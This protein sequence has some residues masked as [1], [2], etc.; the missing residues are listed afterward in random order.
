MKITTK[1][2]KDYGACSDQLAVFNENWPDGCE[3]TVDNLVLAAQ[4]SLFC[5]CNT[6]C[7]AVIPIDILFLETFFDNDCE[8]FH[9]Y[10]RLLDEIEADFK[11]V[12]WDP[13]NEWTTAIQREISVAIMAPVLCELTL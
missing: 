11:S 9:E 12:A 13:G 4:M 1:L 2:L 3:P 8:L 5:N 7:K 10:F 6:R